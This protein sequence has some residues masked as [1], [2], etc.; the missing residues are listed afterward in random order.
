MPESA[1]QRRGEA[2]VL[3][4]EV[5]GVEV[6]G[7]E[8]AVLAD[9]ACVR[10]AGLNRTPSVVQGARPLGAGRSNKV[11]LV[12]SSL[13]PEW[14]ERAACRGSVAMFFPQNGG[15]AMADVAAARRVCTSCPVRT[16]CLDMAIRERIHDGI[17]GGHTPRER[18]RIA[19]DLDP[20]VKRK[21]VEHG[22]HR[23]YLQHQRRGEQPCR[24]CV[25]AHTA[26]HA[27]RKALRVVEGGA[28]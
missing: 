6:G 4:S 9:G 12:S 15:T 14:M 27:T 26:Y 21:P 20:F 24:E 17:W 23:G 2:V 19:R 16:E 25:A 11:G 18:R 28:S 22:T 7:V 5:P 3:L 10:V 8:G 13:Q 1:L